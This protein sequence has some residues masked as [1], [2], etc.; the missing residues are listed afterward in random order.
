MSRSRSPLRSAVRSVVALV[1]LGV[2]LGMLAGCTTG[3]PGDTA[4][5][6]PTLPTTAS[7]PAPPTLCSTPATTPATTPTPAPLVVQADAAAAGRR[8]D[9]AEQL[10]TAALAQEGADATTLGCAAAGLRY[11]DAGRAADAAAAKAE[12]KSAEQASPQRAAT[13]W[14]AFY[15]T[16]VRPVLQVALPALVVLA[17]LLALSSAAT[18]WVVRGD[19]CGPRSPAGNAHLL[20]GRVA[21]V[22]ALA[23]SA[24]AAVLAAPRL[25]HD[26]PALARARPLLLVTLAVLALVVLVAVAA[27]LVVGHPPSSQGAGMRATTILGRTTLTVLVLVVGVVAGLALPATAASVLIAAVVLALAAA[28]TLARLQGLRLR[29]VVGAS[30]VA[31]GHDDLLAAAVRSRLEALGSFS[32]GG[33]RVQQGTDVDT[34][35]TDALGLLPDGPWRQVASFAARV[36]TAPP[37]WQA[38]VTAMPDGTLGVTLRRNGRVIGATL[39]SPVAMHL[40]TAALAA[41]PAAQGTPLTDLTTDRAGRALT[42]GVAASLLVELARRHDHLRPGLSGATEWSSVAL[43]AL[44]TDPAMQY[45]DEQAARLATLA[46]SLDTGYLGAYVTSVVLRAKILPGGA[47]DELIVRDLGPTVPEAS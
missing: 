16:W 21:C 31:G 7:A 33:V 41:L 12:E 32:A 38:D 20:V 40:G 9:V 34:L 47:G 4:G 45:D 17:A 2:L 39:V 24:V 27:W 43:L 6:T 35:P 14:D 26:A 11:V 13:A 42:T 36:L 28:A 8:W 5:G 29:V 30:G 22:A 23:W 37:P 10:Y 46:T 25:L 44:A 1:L 15:K 18:S 3:D 19:S